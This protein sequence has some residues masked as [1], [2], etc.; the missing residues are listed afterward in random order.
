M[1][2]PDRKAGGCHCHCN[3]CDGGHHCGNPPNC[4][5]KR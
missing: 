4:N 3:A 1:G 2:I 5:V